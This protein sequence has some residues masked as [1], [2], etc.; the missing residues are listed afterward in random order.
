MPLA[1]TVTIE[2][3]GKSIRHTTGIG[4]NRHT[5]GGVTRSSNIN[6]TCFI[7]SDGRAF[8]I[9]SRAEEGVPLL[10]AVIMEFGGKSIS[11]GNIR[12]NWCS[13]GGTTIPGDKNVTC[14][15]DGYSS[16]V[17]VTPR[18]KKGMPL[19]YAVAIKFS[20]KGIIIG[21]VGVNRCTPGGSTPPG[22]KNITCCIYGYGSTAVAIR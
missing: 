17:V 4:V 3:C 13:P 15:I 1:Y 9:V 2:P 8:I 20:Y 19:V 18:T 7:H 5:P 16:T 11:Q 6:V 14:C 10:C 22:D 12:I 21:N